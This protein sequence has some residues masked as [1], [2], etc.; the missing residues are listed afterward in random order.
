VRRR[1]RRGGGGGGGAEE[2]AAAA[3]AE[4]VNHC[5]KVYKLDAT[6]ASWRARHVSHG[7]VCARCAPRGHGATG[8]HRGMKKEEEERL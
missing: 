1:R 3:A 7:H 2:A 8:E 6:F 4:F 5:K